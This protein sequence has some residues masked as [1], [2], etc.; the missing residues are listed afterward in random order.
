MAAP[1]LLAMLL[2][3]VAFWS[4]AFAVVFARS[5]TLVLERERSASW[6]QTLATSG[7]RA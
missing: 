1:M 5:R 7:V 2:M 3:T 4:Y 6:V